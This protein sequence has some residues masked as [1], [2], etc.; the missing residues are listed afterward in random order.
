MTT[1]I[2]QSIPT[3]VETEV[4]QRQEVTVKSRKIKNISLHFVSSL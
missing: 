2:M 4:R 1:V 3:S